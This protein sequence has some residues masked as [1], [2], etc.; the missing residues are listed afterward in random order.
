MSKHDKIVVVVFLGHDT[1]TAMPTTKS[2]GKK[3]KKER[4]VQS[5]L[6]VGQPKSSVCKICEFSYF[7]SLKKSREQHEFVHNE[8]LYGIQITSK[9]L[10][11]K[12]MS[13]RNSIETR[14]ITIEKEKKKIHAITLS[15]NDPPIR[16]LV[17]ETLET[18][19]KKWLNNTECSENWKTRPNESKVVLLLSEY[20]KQLRVIGITTTDPPE[21]GLQTIIGFHLNTQTSTVDERKPKLQLRLGVSRIFVIPTYRGHGLAKMMLDSVLKHA[22]YGTL[23]TKWQIGFSQPSGAGI[24]L[25]NSWYENPPTVPVYEE[26]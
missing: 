26:Q 16:K 24:R 22:V 14:I 13:F 23:L 6:V 2:G 8:F 18:L 5:V 17:G 25:I 15:C 21:K 19:N 12:L 9:H 20:K 4:L 10:Q 1:L 7:K 11:Q 3:G